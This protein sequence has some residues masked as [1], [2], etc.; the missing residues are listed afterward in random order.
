[1][2]VHVPLEFLLAEEANEQ[3]DNISRSAL[4]ETTDDT[5]SRIAQLQ[6]SRAFHIYEV[7]RFLSRHCG[8]SQ[9]ARR[10]VAHRMSRALDIA[11]PFSNM[12]TG[13]TLS[14]LERIAGK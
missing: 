14:L 13:D 12:G 3:A 2:N 7:A 6:R 10:G 9:D 8:L 4:E 5:N 1:M 11:K